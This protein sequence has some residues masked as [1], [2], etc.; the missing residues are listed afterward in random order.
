[1]DRN[2]GSIKAILIAVLM[3]ALFLGAGCSSA[4]SKKPA[5]EILGKTR[6]LALKPISGEARM[7]QLVTVEAGGDG[8]KT[9]ELARAYAYEAAPDGKTIAF[10]GEDGIY[11]ISPDGSWKSRISELS[12]RFDLNSDE[13]KLVGRVMSWA[14]DGSRLAFVCGGDLYVVGAKTGQEPILIAKRTPDVLKTVA[15]AP[16]LAPHIEGI[17]CPD[18]TDNENLIYQDYYSK[19]DGQWQ[20]VCNIM[21]INVNS[22]KKSVLIS[23]GQEPALSPDRTKILYHQEDASDGQV[24]VADIDGGGVKALAPL[25]DRDRAAQRYSWSPDGR[26]AVFERFAVN[27]ET[28][29]RAV[30]AGEPSPDSSGVQRGKITGPAAFSPDGGWVMIPAQ[31]GPIL[32]K[33]GKGSFS[34][35]T[36]AAFEAFK[37]LD[38]ISWIKG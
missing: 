24:K 17:V 4:S 36:S 1:M 6:L 19:Y 23:G 28:G 8:I 14:P 3:A 16:A 12:P 27:T 35:D 18:W 26:Y 13:E 37:G 29:K 20:H 38:H 2:N 31:G 32:L 25:L 21:K 10:V 7:K 34:Y 9:N 22:G 5:A 15:G 33:F 11:L 30:Y